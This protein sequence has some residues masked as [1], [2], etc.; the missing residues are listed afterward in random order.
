M[1]GRVVAERIIVD[2][3]HFTDAQRMLREPRPYTYLINDNMEGWQVL[4]RWIDP[5]PP[6]RQRLRAWLRSHLDEEDGE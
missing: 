6:L 2:S 1:K 4:I 5:R 3:V